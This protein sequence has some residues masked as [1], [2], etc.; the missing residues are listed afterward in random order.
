MLNTTSIGEDYKMGEKRFFNSYFTEHI[1][2]KLT[3]K[4]YPVRYVEGVYELTDL[5]NELAEE[6]RELRNFIELMN[7]RQKWKLYNYKRD[8]D[9]EKNCKVEVGEN[10]KRFELDVRLGM[11]KLLIDNATNKRY[12]LLLINDIEDIVDLLNEQQDTITELKSIINFASNEGDLIVLLMKEI[13]KLRQEA[14]ECRA[15][16]TIEK[17]VSNYD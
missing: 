14:Q 16:E 8:N 11:P 13:I 2:D 12:H 7:M 3:D 5:L 17:G 10:V 6:N 15:Y 1:I 9:S 4:C